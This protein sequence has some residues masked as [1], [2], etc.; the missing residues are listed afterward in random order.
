ML[1]W[2]P[3]YLA[4]WC[5]ILLTESLSEPALPIA[6]GV[7]LLL[8]GVLS[9]HEVGRRWR[10]GMS[11]GDVAFLLL[12]LL[13]AAGTLTQAS[14]A[15]LFAATWIVGIT[16]LDRRTDNASTRAQCVVAIGIVGTILSLT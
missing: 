14:P 5:L 7:A 9:V 15:F 4:L 3:F 2:A 12:V 10:E 13:G 1:R 16:G 8:L 6:R 11:N